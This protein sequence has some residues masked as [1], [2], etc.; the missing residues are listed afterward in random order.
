MGPGAPEREGWRRSGEMG[1]PQAKV[2]RR[3]GV[4]TV[5]MPCTPT[6]PMVSAPGQV[7]R[8][9]LTVPAKEETTQKIASLRLHQK[10]FGECSEVVSA[11]SPFTCT[12][13]SP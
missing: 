13:A 6:F 10:G 7:N 3:K 2:T 5:T 11:V 8:E 9:E 4:S 12:D 1:T